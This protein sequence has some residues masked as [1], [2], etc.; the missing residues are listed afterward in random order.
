MLCAMLYALCEL[1]RFRYIGRLRSLRT[2]GD[3]ELYLLSCTKG[4]ETIPRNSWIVDEYIIAASLLD[5]SISLFCV[6]PLHDSFCQDD[7]PPFSKQFLQ[8]HLISLINLDVKNLIS[9]KTLPSPG[10][11]GLRGGGWNFSCGQ[12]DS[13]ENHP[14]THEG[15]PSN[16]L[17]QEKV[18]PDQC[19][20]GFKIK[21]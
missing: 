13:K 6:K 12:V 7:C 2:L 17:I 21:I 9:L 18:G 15:D 11:R 10:G 5:E 16:L 19:H 3:L 4:F 20:K 1:T 8:R 14:T